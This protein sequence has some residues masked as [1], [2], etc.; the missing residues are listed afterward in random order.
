[1]FPIQIS[2]TIST[3]AQLDQ[4]SAVVAKI[5]ADTVAGAPKLEAAAA[6]VEKPKKAAPAK[7]AP[8]EPTAAQAD[9]PAQST[10]APAPQPST[11]EGCRCALC[12]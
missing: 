8:S 4:L 10:A 12:A 2:L 7:T 3:P 1:M 11:G 5:Y 9:A 6:Q